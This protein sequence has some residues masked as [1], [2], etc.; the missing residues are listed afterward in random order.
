MLVGWLTTGETLGLAMGHAGSNLL[1]ALSNSMRVTDEKISFQV[2][3]SLKRAALAFSSE[4]LKTCA[5]VG[6]TL[7]ANNFLYGSEWFLTIE[8][9]RY[10]T[11]SFNSAETL[12]KKAKKRKST[13]DLRQNNLH[14]NTY[15]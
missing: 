14:Y 9:I 8:S 1:T 15:Y 12:R 13:S 5:K 2:P 11:V 3:R 4:Y 7:P 6:T 10:K